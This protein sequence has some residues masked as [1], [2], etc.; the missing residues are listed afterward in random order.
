MLQ[1]QGA[2][3]NIRLVY[4]LAKKEREKEEKEK[5]SYPYDSNLMSYEPSLRLLRSVTKPF[6]SK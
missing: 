6:G 2:V 3:E 1:Q 4:F 5:R